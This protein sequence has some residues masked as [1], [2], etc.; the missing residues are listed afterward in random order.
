MVIAHVYFAIRPEKWWMT[1]SMIKGWITREE[2]VDHFDP[3]QWPVAD[4]PASA[5]T[6]GGSGAP[7]GTAPTHRPE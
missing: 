3:K 7:V 5:P 1:R 6:S 2:Y 4:T